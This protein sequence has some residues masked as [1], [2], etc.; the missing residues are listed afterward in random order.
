MSNHIGA[1]LP[2]VWRIFTESVEYY[3]RS[4]VNSLELHEDPIDEDGLLLLKFLIH[5]SFTYFLS[6]AKFINLI[7]LFADFFIHLFVSLSLCTALLFIRSLFFF[8]FVH[9]LKHQH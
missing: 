8:L 4:V 2:P 9:M 7:C 3:V 6:H 1:I 5:Q